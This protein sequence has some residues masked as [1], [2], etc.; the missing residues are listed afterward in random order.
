LYK[1]NK[2]LDVMEQCGEGE[3][4]EE[5]ATDGSTGFHAVSDY[6]FPVAQSPNL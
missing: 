3:L 5:E 4:N 1:Q 6:N 2:E